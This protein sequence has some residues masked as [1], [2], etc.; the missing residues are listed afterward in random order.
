MNQWTR[1]FQGKS[2]KVIY[3]CNAILSRSTEGKIW[4]VQVP[5]GSLPI[6]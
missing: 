4:V 5:P 6:F 3:S 1:K 2:D